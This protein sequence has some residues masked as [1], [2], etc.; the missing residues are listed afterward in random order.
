MEKEANGND[1]VLVIFAHPDDAEFTSGGT[2]GKWALEGRKVSYVVCTDGSKGAET[3]RIDTADL[4]ATRQTEQR[5]AAVILGVTDITFL[6]CPDGELVDNRG[7]S[8]ELTRMIRV[9]RPQTLLT[10]DPWRPYQLHADHRVTGYA[11]LDAVMAAGNPRYFPEQLVDGLEP[12]QVEEVYLF[13]T[14]QPDIWVDISA[15]F[16]LKVEAIRQHSSQ[17]GDWGEVI[18]H[19][20]EWNSRVGRDK[21]FAYAESFKL[22]QPRC[23]ICR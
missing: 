14:D 15:S 16:D 10:W 13:G 9:L 4:I 3:D 19:V 11:A 17:I 22:L 12:H 20:T 7:I 8:A 23:S 6:K 21:G 1:R 2:I 5:R 18:Q